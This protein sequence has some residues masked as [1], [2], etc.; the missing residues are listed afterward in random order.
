L[1]LVALAVG[2]GLLTGQWWAPQVVVWQ[3][4]CFLALRMATIFVSPERGINE[5]VLQLLDPNTLQMMQTGQT[6]GQWLGLILLLVW[7]GLL[8]WFLNRASVKA[9]FHNP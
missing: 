3:A 6:I 5:A 2:I 8:I 4:G 9:Q 7:N 1:S